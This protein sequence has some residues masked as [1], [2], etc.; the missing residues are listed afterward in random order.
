MFAVLSIK[1]I[2]VKYLDCYKNA[3]WIQDMTLTL[4]MSATEKKKKKRKEA[5]GKLYAEGRMF[6]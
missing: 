2:S 1:N 5:V 6:S 4:F 3:N